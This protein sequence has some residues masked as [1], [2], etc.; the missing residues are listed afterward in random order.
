M[1]ACML[2]VGTPAAAQRNQVTIDA[3]V[4]RGTVGYAR[5]IKPKA[6][7]GIEIGFG[8]PQID[9]TF[10]PSQDATDGP[11]FEEYLHVGIFVRAA[12]SEHF[13]GDAGIRASIAD[14][15]PCDAS[16]CW[17]APFVGAYIQPMAGWQKFKV[18]PRLVAGWIN[19][20][21]EGTTGRG[22]TGVVALN[23]L[24]ARLTIPW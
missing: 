4:I 2:A 16:D 19:E 7:A 8:F 9:R 15:W 3:S 21:Q 6:Y 17:P 18:G 24:T 11:D 23:P 5:A 12:P 20:D 13:E 1:A 22:N 14:L 10:H